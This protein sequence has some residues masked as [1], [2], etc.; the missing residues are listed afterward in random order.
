MLKKGIL[1]NDRIYAN[2]CHTVKA[3]KKF[4]T[5]INETFKDL[6]KKIYNK[7]LKEAVP[8]GVKKMGFNKVLK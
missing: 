7:K 6:S 1:S 2:Y 4:E 5:A 8:L 3:K